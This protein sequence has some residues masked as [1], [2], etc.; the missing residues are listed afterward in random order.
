M[1]I[2]APG[3]V[4]RLYQREGLE[5]GEVDFGGIAREVCLAHVPGVRAGDHVMVHAGFALEIIDES[6]M[7]RFQQLWREVLTGGPTG[8]ESP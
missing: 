2:A 8:E 1:C 5:M 3:R 7:A 6:E 4:I